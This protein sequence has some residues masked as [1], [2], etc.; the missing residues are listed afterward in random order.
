RAL[1]GLF[2][3][4][5]A[6]LVRTGV[7]AAGKLVPVSVCA[8]ADLLK[9]TVAMAEDPQTRIRIEDIREQL[10]HAKAHEDAGRYARG[11][12]LATTAVERA[13]D[14][15]YMPLLAETLL[16]R[17]RLALASDDT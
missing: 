5:D 17:G 8:E 3:E 2:S 4:A 11:T 15:G 10:A 16:R 13:R 12:A 1:I 6:E 9:A 7:T 14:V